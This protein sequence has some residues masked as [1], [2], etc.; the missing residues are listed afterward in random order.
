MFL[1]L[2]LFVQLLFAFSSGSKWKYTHDNKP[3]HEGQCELTDRQSPIKLVQTGQCD[4]LLQPIVIRN[5]R[6]IVPLSAVNNGHA[7]QVQAI[8][9]HNLDRLHVDIDGTKY[10]LKQF[11]FHWKG[12]PYSAQG[13]EH[14]LDGKFYDAEMHMV[15]ADPDSEVDGVHDK[16]AVLGFLIQANRRRDN[17]AF[18]KIFGIGLSSLQS[19]QDDIAHS[20]KRVASGWMR[21]G[22]LLDHVDMGDYYRYEGSLTT[23]PCS[24]N[25]KWTVF[26]EPLRIS[27]HQLRQLQSLPVIGRIGNYREAFD[28]TADNKVEFSC[29]KQ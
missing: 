23:P 18:R 15:F 29:V 2:L 12:G 25:V 7:L 8:P 4:P 27:H 26:R 28:A 6:S 16:Y 3:W 21:I 9:G 14:E 22:D 19:S 11:H 5:I 13:S 24:E 10:R 1:A 20:Q 17:H